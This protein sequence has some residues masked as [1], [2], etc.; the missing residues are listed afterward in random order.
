MPKPT[1]PFAALAAFALPL[2]AEPS[3]PDLEVTRVAGEPQLRNIVSV[4]VDVDGTLYAAETERRKAADLDIRETM[5]WLEEDLALRTIEDKRRLYREGITTERFEGHKSMTDRTG[6]GRLDWRDLTTHS[7]RIHRLTD[8]DGDGIYEQ[9]QV[10]AEDFNSEVTGIAAG[11]LAH[12][13]EVYATIA[14]DVWRMRDTDGDGVADERESIAHGF[15]VHINYAGHDMHGLTLGPD[16]RLYWTIGDKAVNVV[17]EGVRHEYPH[18]GA[19]LRCWPDGSGFE[20]FAHGLRNVQEIA[21]DDFGNIFGV[22]N[23]S[24]RQGEKERFVF[25]PE[26]SDT[27]WRVYYQYRGEKYN[28]WMVERIAFPDGGEA[29]YRPSLWLKPIREYVDG[30]AGFARDPGTALSE[31]YRGRFFL[32]QFPAG[33]IRAFTI[34]PD[35]AGFRM[36]DEK[37]LAEGGT[38]VGA[39]I[40]PDGALYVADW[41]GGY[42]LNEIGGVWKFD[43]PQAAE[44]PARRQVAA[45]L[46]AGPGEVPSDT[47][48]ERLG[49][50]DQRIRI[51]AQW[52]LARREEWETLAKVAADPESTPVAIAHALWGLTQ[53][54]RFDEGLF[55]KLAGSELAEIRG[56]AAKWAGETGAEEVAL[57]PLLADPEPRVRFLA[58]IAASKL[59]EERFVEPLLQIASANADADPW[60]RHAA[61]LGLSACAAPAELMLA[62]HPE[63][64]VQRVCILALR[65]AIDHRVRVRP[66]EADPQEILGRDLAEHQLALA[67]FLSVRDPGVLNDAAIAIHA[68]PASPLALPELA[69]LIDRRPDAAE[70]AI[71]R[72]IAACRHLGDAASLESLARFAADATRPEALR[73]H[74]LEVLASAVEPLTLDPVD[75]RYVDLPAAALNSSLRA[76]L[77]ALLG[78]IAGS[79]ALATAAG[80][81]LDAVGERLGPEQLAERVGDDS[82]RPALRLISLGALEREDPAAWAEAAL[83]LLDAEQPELRA[84][85]A[86]QLSTSEPQRVFRYLEGIGLGSSDLAERQAS[87]RLLPELG[88]DAARARLSQLLAAALEGDDR[89]VLDILEAAKAGGLDTAAVEGELGGSKRELLRGGDVERGRRLFEASLVANC[90]ACH[91][92]EGAGSDVGPAL[93][94][95]GEKPREYLLQSLIEP[96]AVVAEGYPT[97]SSMPPMGLIL[98]PAQ[99]RDLV[100]FLASLK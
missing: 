25:I 75:G 68:E 14:P 71:R 26:G 53:G 84:A 48:V 1:R 19:L 86:Q 52:E 91:R 45:M 93:A 54:R 9:H 37:I 76:N 41:G 18:Q 11:V 61:A 62:G 28:P 55:A 88:L 99:I 90:S 38:F 8:P 56:Q 59:G 6:D 42:A 43:D 23:D 74:A 50:A 40:G 73:V 85:A 2:A 58:A 80:E 83:A 30:P 29:G 39:C 57:E 81:A 3:S 27:G 16:G 13:G 17:S 94:G 72:S 15:G 78:S 64:A 96:Q 89:V 36:G 67:S 24:D 82:L 33:F 31:A 34:E 98:Q 32:T 51:D 95:I 63:P 87:I 12:R 69:R 44:A 100:E 60:L 49:H 7:E 46:R 79:D 97:P 77:G 65:R 4:S 10:F 66:V 35:G 92:V 22:D 70:P 5:F 47:L 20:V 21:F